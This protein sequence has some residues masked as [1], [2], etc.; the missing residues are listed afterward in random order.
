MQC[1]R[2]TIVSKW[3]RIHNVF[4][5]LF[6]VFVLIKWYWFHRKHICSVMVLK[7]SWNDTIF[8]KISTQWCCVAFVRL[9]CYFLEKKNAMQLLCFVMTFHCSRKYDCND[10]KLLLSYNDVIFRKNIFSD[11]VLQLSFN[12]I[13]FMKT[14][15]QCNDVAF[16]S[17][18]VCFQENIFSVSWCSFVCKL[19]CLR[20]NVFAMLLCWYYC[21][22]IIFSI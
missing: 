17:K 7:L 14:F 1:F 15:I 21:L 5:W 4:Q 22:I 18:W 9:C 20:W 10:M 6:D 19:Y 2:V 13:I 11:V 12:Y 8:M 3:Y 16:V